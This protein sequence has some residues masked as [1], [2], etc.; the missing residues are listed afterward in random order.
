M[1]SVASRSGSQQDRNLEIAKSPSE[2]ISVGQ[3]P[4]D[5]GLNWS[6]ASRGRL[7]HDSSCAV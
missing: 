5:F 3:S 2:G 1:A 6:S 7:M 4:E